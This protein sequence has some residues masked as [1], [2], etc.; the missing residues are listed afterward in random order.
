MVNRIGD[1]SAGKTMLF[2]TMCAEAVRRPW[3]QNHK[4]RLDDAEAANM[5][6]IKALFGAELE[7]KLEG[8]G[9]AG[10][11]DSVEDFYRN[12]ANLLE[13]REPFIYG[14]DSMDSLETAAGRKRF[15]DKRAKANEAEAEGEETIEG[16]GSYGDGKAKFNS[17]GLR[18]V[19][20][21]L[22]RT[23]SLLFIISQTRD[24]ITS[25]FA[26][27][28]RSGG[29]ALKFY[30]THEIWLA[31]EEVIYKTVNGR[32]RTV[33]HWIKAKVSKNKATGAYDIVSFPILYDYGVDDI[34]SC[35]DYLC[36]EGVWQR[37][38]GGLIDSPPFGGG[39]YNTEESV[40]LMLD[41]DEEA[42]TELRALVGRTWLDIQKQLQPNR[43]RRFG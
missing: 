10:C 36:V 15:E 34:T 11:S 13:E 3:L 2:L 8:V 22:K 16:K 29:R 38:K 12:V 37:H 26:P 23:D 40:V 41:Q 20:R 43:A 18:L 39:P 1:S 5:F 7:A 42:Q 33:G 24:N 32:K 6:D 25:R 27:K 19:C 30:A 9:T 4:I 14:L 21:D 31:V 17:E 28:T 35:V